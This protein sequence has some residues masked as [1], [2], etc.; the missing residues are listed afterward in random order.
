M[1]LSNGYPNG[2]KTKWSALAGERH[3]EIQHPPYLRAGNFTGGKVGIRVTFVIH[4]LV[5]ATRRWY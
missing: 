5:L 3:I 4:Q 2:A 1:M